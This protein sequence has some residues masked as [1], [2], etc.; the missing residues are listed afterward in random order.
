MRSVRGI[1]IVRRPG[2]IR[3][4]GGIHHDIRV[5]ILLRAAFTLVAVLILGS[6]LLG[7]AA[8]NRSTRSLVEL[9]DQRMQSTAHVATVQAAF[10]VSTQDGLTLLTAVG[11]GSRS[12]AE[13]QAQMHDQALDA[14]WTAYRRHSPAADAHTLQTFETQLATY[15]QQRE[16]LAPVARAGDLAGYALRA[17]ATVDGTS[18]SLMGTLAALYQAEDKAAQ[19]ALSDAQ[20]AG[21]DAQ[22]LVAAA[23]LTSIAV[24]VL[25]A[26]VLVR[27]M[28]GPL[29]RV[30]AV[31][32]A[33]KAGRLGE[34]V[35]AGHRNEFGETARALDEAME[36]LSDM[37]RR[38]AAHAAALERSSAELTDISA[39]LST[40]A[41]RELAQ[42]QA[43]SSSSNQIQGNGAAMASSSA[44]LEA[45]TRR[46][47]SAADQAATVASSAVASAERAST[48]VT[49]LG[50]SSRDIGDVVEVITR[51]AGQTNLLALNAAIEAARAGRAG[52]GFAVVAEEVK[53]LARQTARA[54]AGITT[55]VTAAQQDAEAATD[56]IDRIT[57]VVA[58]I[59]GL[60]AAIV[61]AVEEQ[62]ATT[63]EVV[64]NLDE[65]S[66]GTEAISRTAAGVAEAAQHTAR[67]AADTVAASRSVADVAHDLNALVGRF[68]F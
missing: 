61:A 7:L 37:V 11:G 52:V 67:A 1:R 20:R 34:R 43:V 27:A 36:S 66:S 41:E 26:Q 35:G 59:D 2:G 39:G 40:S 24:L 29:D 57:T 9:Y 49:A 22:L 32:E 14:A 33:L 65:V 3:R 28:V 25:L 30:R 48:T 55:K 63:A 62:T 8:L 46:I 5:A 23:A 68:E 47:A 53:G 51:I 19:S 13:Q 56:S 21:Q 58:Q 45:A 12:V 54:T 15:R 42:A 4:L 44:G 60:Q 38:I 16:A 18:A 6:N 64:R 50:G 31:A 10:L 17:G